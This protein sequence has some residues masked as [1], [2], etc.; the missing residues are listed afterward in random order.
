M[1]IEQ[2]S[3]FSAGYQLTPEKI[4]F[5]RSEWQPGFANNDY[6]GLGVITEIWSSNLEGNG[7]KKL[8]TGKIRAFCHLG[9]DLFLTAEDDATHQGSELYEVS[10]TEGTKRCL[11]RLDMLIGSLHAHQGKIY[12][13]ARGFWKNNSIFL[14]DSSGPNLV[15]LIDSPYSET[16]VFADDSGLTFNANY[17]GRNGCYHYDQDSKEITRFSGCE[18]LSDAVR[19]GSETYF[20]SLDAGG[21]D[22]YADALVPIHYEL[23]AQTHPEPPYHR[24]NA[25][26]D[27]VLDHIPVRKGSYW[28]NLKHLVNPRVLRLPYLASSAGVPDSLIT[29]KD[30][31]IGVQLSGADA[32]GDFPIW[33]AAL[34]WD[35]AQKRPR[36]QLDLENNFFRPVKQ[37]LSYNNL[38]GHTLSSRQYV[39]L[40]KR[41]N[42]G[43]SYAGAGFGFTSAENFSRKIWDPFLDLDLAAP[44]LRIHTSNRLM[45]E[46]T[47][48]WPSDR[49][50][51]GWQGDL[52]LRLRAPL[53]TEIRANLAAA[54]DP[55]ADSNEVFPGMRGWGGSI[56]QNTGIRGG[57]TWYAPVLKV[58]NGIWNPNL[59]LGD[60]NL[61]L[62]FD[63]NR[64]RWLA[65]PSGAT[66]ADNDLYSWG[67]EL[68]AEISAGYLL[69]FN[70]GLRLAFCKGSSK[71]VL[72]LILGL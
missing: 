32:T 11:G 64:G 39:P 70:A 24:L 41:M 69:S 26:A 20:L 61:G 4:Y 19:L 10:A 22:I 52:S 5:S 48:F 46:T 45:L 18:E 23:P 7:R 72:E 65:G 12:A 38:S 8:F 21:Y 40:M 1:L 59:Y 25:D 47:R 34:A 14:L 9:D 66:M 36:W 49:D 51:L 37:T 3:D 60:V 50:R 35:I 33:T 44:G 68:I 63:Y 54:W 43:L 67:A 13:S 57:L 27:T 42:Y 53:T 29:L 56:P 2:N 28:N 58:R 62:F 16:L 30:M 6:D 31:V 17:G 71:P 55:S 15:P